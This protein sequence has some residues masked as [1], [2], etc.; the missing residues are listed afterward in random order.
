MKKKDIS[1]IFNL[2]IVI[3]ELLGLYLTLKTNKRIGFEYYT[4][5]SNMLCLLCSSL[6]LIN[7]YFSKKTPKWLKLFKYA[8]TVCL[9]LT[10]VTVLFIL[11]PMYNFNYNFLL[12]DGSLFYYHLI[13]PILAISTFLFF[14]DIGKIKFKDTIYATFFTIIYSLV[15]IPLNIVHKITGPYPFLKVYELGVVKSVLWCILLLS[16]SYLVSHIIGLL[17]NKFRIKK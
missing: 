5:D 15:L 3:F 2:L 14:D 16:L 1:I 13:C 17:Y 9:G 7:M 8:S 6:F 4:E 12:F 11:L 10:F